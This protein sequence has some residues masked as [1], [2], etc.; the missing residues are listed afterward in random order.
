MHKRDYTKI[1]LRF[2]LHVE[3]RIVC[4]KC[5]SKLRRFPNKSHGATDLFCVDSDCR[6]EVNAKHNEDSMYSTHPQSRA[7]LTDLRKKIG[8]RSI[9]FAVGTEKALLLHCLATSKKKEFKCNRVRGKNKVE[10]KR[11]RYRFR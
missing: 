2:E 6:V 9:F 8:A 3:A 4:P 10:Q 11:L 5:G 1:A 7:A